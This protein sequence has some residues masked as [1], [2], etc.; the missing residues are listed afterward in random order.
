MIGLFGGTCNN[1]YVF[2][3]ALNCW[4]IP[5]IL[6]LDRKD[7]FPHS[8]PVWEDIDFFFKSGFDQSQIDWAK[9]EKECDW[10]EPEWFYHPE[11]RPGGLKKILRLSPR[12]LFVRFTGA[13]YL[14]T[15]KEGSAIFEKL[16]ECD[17]LI[18]CGVLPAI[19][20]MLTG[21]PYIIFP[22]G[23]DMRIAVGVQSKGRGFKA[24]LIDWL[25]T[26]SFKKAVLIGS[27]LPDGSAEVDAAEYKRLRNLSIE[28]IPTPY[29][30]KVRL[31]RASRRRLL[32]LLFKNIDLHLP[33]ADCYAF[34]PS[35][36]NFHW[37]GHDRLLA[38][39]SEYRENLTIHFI[40]IGWGDDYKE[41][42]AYIRKNHLE[43][44]VTVIP[45]FFS[46]GLL[47]QFFEAIDFIIDEFNGSGS[48]GT[49]LSEAMS[50]G[51]PVVTWIS[52]MFDKPGWEKPPVIQARTKE[53]LKHVIQGIATHEISLNEYSRK[54]AEWFQ[55]T[56][57]YD[58]V[59]AAFMSRLGRYMTGEE[60]KIS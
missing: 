1:M 44:H 22:H 43:V 18:V 52:D 16:L 10:K 48:Y 9:F 34:T 59:R 53:E 60:G 4:G 6:I 5:A 28:R 32:A 24:L 23:T 38:A 7:N 14:H 54:T 37:K 40:F 50:R 36:I 33:D 57:S 20:A 56:H 12:N 47:F 35:R 45:A 26:Q 8:Q 30:P 2:A 46:K 25:L 13:R 3:K 11:A 31:D 29:I 19:T 58:A 27:P 42:L 41:A 49:A 51:C 15:R 17:F 21:K 39:I 55:R